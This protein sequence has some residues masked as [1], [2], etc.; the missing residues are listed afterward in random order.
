LEEYVFAKV[1]ELGDELYSG[2]ITPNPYEGKGEV[3]NACQWCPYGDVCGGKGD[4]RWLVTLKP[5][6]LWN[7]VE[8]GEPNG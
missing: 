5:E 1:A 2:R 3:G 7:L 6:A 8:G 4:V